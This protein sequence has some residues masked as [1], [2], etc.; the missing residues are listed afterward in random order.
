MRRKGTIVHCRATLTLGNEI[1]SF[2]SAASTPSSS[3]LQFKSIEDLRSFEALL[4]KIDV[5]MA[6]ASFILSSK[7]PLRLLEKFVW[8]MDLPWSTSAA[9]EGIRLCFLVIICDGSRLWVAF[10]G[11]LNIKHGSERSELAIF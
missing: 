1:I 5:V 7:G 3:H 4:M 6:S 8:P 11:E 10:S 2:V 9:L